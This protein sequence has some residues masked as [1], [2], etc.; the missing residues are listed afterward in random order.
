MR[1]VGISLT[2]DVLDRIDALRILDGMP[3]RS[4]MLAELIGLGLAFR[5]SP[6]EAVAVIIEAMEAAVGIEPT[7]DPAPAWSGKI[8]LR[9][10][11]P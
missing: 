1:Q 11:S 7:A 10:P 9:D 3:S 8:N 2:D 5:E 6:I 4:A